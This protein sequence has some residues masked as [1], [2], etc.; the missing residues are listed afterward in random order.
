M[1]ISRA[2]YTK[3]AEEGELTTSLLKI[4]SM[5]PF[6]CDKK[7]QFLI[8]KDRTDQMK[9]DE[10]VSLQVFKNHRDFRNE[11]EL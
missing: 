2:P 1:S 4:S 3:L 6:E 5:K 7:K 11:D 10:S 9:Q 8:S